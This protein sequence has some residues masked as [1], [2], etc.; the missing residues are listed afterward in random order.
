MLQ[1]VWTNK[2]RGTESHYIEKSGDDQYLAQLLTE[3]EDLPHRKQVPHITEYNLKY[4]RI[5]N[6][7]TIIPK[8]KRQRC[9]SN[10]MQDYASSEI[11]IYYRVNFRDSP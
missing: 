6:F 2:F 11:Y 9:A 3:Q 4:V 5:N 10:V 8:N 1:I 7:L